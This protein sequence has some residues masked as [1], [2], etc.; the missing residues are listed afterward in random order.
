MQTTCRALFI[1]LLAV[2]AISAAAACATE[3]TLE[4]AS[5]AALPPAPTMGDEQSTPQGDEAPTRDSA[6]PTDS[7]GEDPVSPTD[8]SEGAEPTPTPSE[9]SEGQA[10]T[11]PGEVCISVA[12][13]ASFPGGA[14][15]L[16]VTFFQSLPPTGPP[17][18]IG[19]EITAPALSADAP[20]AIKMENITATGTLFVYVVAYMPGGGPWMAAPGIDYAGQSAAVVMDGGPINLTSPIMLALEPGGEVDPGGE[21]TT[22]GGTD[23]GGDPSEEPTTGPGTNPEES[24]TGPVPTFTRVTLFDDLPGAAWMTPVDL[25][26][27]GFDELLLSTLSEGLDFLSLPP[28]ANGG[29]YI[30][31][32]DGG[33]PVPGD[34]VGTW[35]AEKKFDQS[36]GYG[37]P[38]KSSLYD[39]DN[40]GVEDWVLAGGFLA[41]PTGYILWMKGSKSGGNHTFGAVQEI[42]IPDATRWYHEIQPVDLD[43]DGD[44]DFVT[45]NNDTMIAGFEGLSYGTSKLEWFENL[46]IP[47][48][49]SFVVHTI[50]EVGG[51]LFTTYDLDADGDEDVLLPQFFGGESLVWMQNPGDPFGAWEMHVIN[52]TT[53]KGFGAEVLDLGGDGQMEI[54]YGNHNHQDADDPEDRIMGI[55]WFDLPPRDEIDT[56][57]DWDAHMNVLY[58][59]FFIPADDPEQEGAP[60]VVHAGDIDGDG[61]M[62][63]TASGDGDKGIYLFIQQAPGQF[64]MVQIDDGLT[65]SGDHVMMD[66]DA[67]GDMDYVWAVFGESGLSGVS[68][69]VYAYIQDGLIKPESTDPGSGPDTDPGVGDEIDPGA[70]PNTDVFEYDPTEAGP[71]SVSSSSTTLNVPGGLFGTNIPLNIFIPDG[72]GPFPVVVMTD[73]FNLAGDLYTSYGDHLASWGFIVVFADIPNNFIFP[74]TPLELI[75]YLGATF[76][77]VEDEAMGQLGGKADVSKLAVAGH[78]AG[79]AAAVHVALYDARPLGVF[80]IDPVD[81]APEFVNGSPEDYPSVAPELMNLLDV[82]VVLLG[83]TTNGDEATATLTPCAPLDENFQQYYLGATGPAL[84]IEVV[85][86]NHMSFLDNPDCGLDCAVC[87]SGTDD[88]TTTRILTQSYMTAFFNVILKGETEFST[89]LTGAEMQADVNAG[90]VITQSKNGF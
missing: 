89:Y 26:G 88:P 27:D 41:K 4:P 31:S 52:D 71:W 77:W 59:G 85:G 19:T 12:V 82:P 13:P 63:V 84:E 74:K 30:L 87:P 10:C 90:L 25:N 32:R 42:A 78:S 72:A 51:A 64:D 5:T 22:P 37:F 39:V 11:A 17:N 80:A 20:I 8:P 7:A 46:G 48:Q 35:S 54:L 3:E 38:N 28:L 66:L 9:P 79:A 62:D 83:E 53:G 67:D 76:D 65:M 43:G 69:F 2:W 34:S 44:L 81:G 61:D 70:D 56:L 21:P 40:D 45:T 15:R 75:D 58:E 49:A 55:Y 18:A 1:T 50:A 86:A 73:G 60:G 57:A 36:A 68:S 14:D 23:P 16:A 29:A 24:A 6:L 47:G 33:A